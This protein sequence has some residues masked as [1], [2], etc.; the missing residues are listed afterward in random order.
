MP[1][2]LYQELMAWSLEQA[3]LQQQTQTTGTS[4]ST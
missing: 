1:T 4:S 2:H 3:A